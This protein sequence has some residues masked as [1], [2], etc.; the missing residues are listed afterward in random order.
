MIRSVLHTAL[1]L[2][3]CPLLAAQQ[4]TANPPQPSGEPSAPETTS[5]P[6]ENPEPIAIPQNATIALTMPEPV[7]E[8]MMTVG[9]PVKFVVAHDVMVNGVPVIRTGTPVNGVI[10]HG[11]HGS[12][13]MDY[14]GEIRIRARD[15][16]SGNP[17]RVRLRGASN[18]DRYRGGNALFGSSS[19]VAT[20]AVVVGVVLACLALLN[21]DR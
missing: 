3:L 1:C 17:I 14:R 6:A 19:G 4:T 2:T 16:Q 15:F 10:T 9:T 8:S 13:P 5:A 12:Y 18:H 11:R 21:G 20:S 7:P